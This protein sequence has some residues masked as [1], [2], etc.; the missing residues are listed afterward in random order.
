MSCHFLKNAL[1]GERMPAGR[2]VD[3][4]S[5]IQLLRAGHLL[6]SGPATDESRHRLLITLHWNDAELLQ[7]RLQPLSCP[8]LANEDAVTFQQR[9]FTGTL[10]TEISASQDAAVHSSTR[11]Y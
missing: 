10:C 5:A 9:G 2:L 6:G 1:A 7:Y 4:D 11:K 8:P 3:K